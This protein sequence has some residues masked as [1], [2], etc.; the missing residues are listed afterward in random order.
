MLVKG[1]L[2]CL[3]CGFMSGEWVGT[4]G[5]PLLV[6]GRRARRPAEEANQAAMVR[7]D[8]CAGPVFLD[9]AEPVISSYRLRR[10]Q[11]MREQLAALDARKGRRAA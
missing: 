8:R 9:A 6:S 5:E 1:E 3:H 4:K 10:I 7:C 11:R 2:K